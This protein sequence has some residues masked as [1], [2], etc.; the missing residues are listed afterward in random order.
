MQNTL[1]KYSSTEL[2]PK[3]SLRAVYLFEIFAETEVAKL[4]KK[5]MKAWKKI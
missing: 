5:S 4:K 3:S 1:G 2:Q